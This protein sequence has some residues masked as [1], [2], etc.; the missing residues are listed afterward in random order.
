MGGG[1]GGGGIPRVLTLVRENGAEILV[2]L[3]NGF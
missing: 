3:G 1:G 2:G